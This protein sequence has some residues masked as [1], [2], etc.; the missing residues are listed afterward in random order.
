V[1]GVN[2]AALTLESLT[3]RRR[4]GSV[5]LSNILVSSVTPGGSAGTASD[6]PMET[7]SF[8][9]SKIDIQYTPQNSN[10]SAGTS[11]TTSCDAH[12]GT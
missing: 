1:L 3:V 5:T 9:F 2:A 7:V 10:G 6:R 4:V 12:T 11:V 8:N